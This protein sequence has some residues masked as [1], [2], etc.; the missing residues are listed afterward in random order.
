MVSKRKFLGVALATLAA[1]S[2]TACGGDKAESFVKEEYPD[3]KILS[4][5]EIQKEFGVKDKECLFKKG[6]FANTAFVF[7]KDDGELKILEVQTRNDKDVSRIK[8]TYTK[9]DPIWNFKSFKSEN[10]KC[11]D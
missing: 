2:L 3:A 8:D 1:F 7:I 11:F 6:N 5:S 4:F 9:D 10:A